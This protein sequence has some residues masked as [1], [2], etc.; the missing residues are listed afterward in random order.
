MFEDKTIIRRRNGQDERKEINNNTE[1]EQKL[2]L[3]RDFLES[4]LIKIDN[5]NRDGRIV[6]L[7]EEKGVIRKIKRRFPDWIITG[8]DSDFPRLSKHPNREKGDFYIRTLT[9]PFPVNLKIVTNTACNLCGT[10]TA[11]SM[12]LYNEYVEDKRKVA[13]FIVEKIPFT[14]EEQH[15]GFVALHKLTGKVKVFTLFSINEEALIKNRTNGFQFEFN[16]L[17]PIKRSQKEGQEFLR[18]QFIEQCEKEAEPYD[19]LRK[20]LVKG[21]GYTRIN[22]HC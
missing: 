15:Y 20:R 11:V 2:T 22:G 21:Y 13:K 14:K 7:E 5:G 19:L 16:K 9:F 18:A 6:S 17:K 12:A 10:T 3:I 1:F 4:R 8:E